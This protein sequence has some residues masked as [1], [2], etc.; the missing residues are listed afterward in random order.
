MGSFLFGCSSGNP[1]ATD[2]DKTSLH[3]ALDAYIDLRFEA[4]PEAT[5]ELVG[6]IE[7]LNLSAADVETMLRAGRASYEPPA[8]KL[9]DYSFDPIDCYHVDYSTKYFIY[10]PAD[11]DASKA[12]PLVFVGHGG[13][14]AMSVDYATSTARSY[15]RTYAPVFGAM[16]GFILVAPAST[17]GWG[18]I[19]NS[20]MFSTISQIE[21]QYHVDP[22]RI[23][24]MGQSMGGHLSYRSGLRFPDHFAAVSPQSGGY[25]Y[26]EMDTVQNLYTI[27]GYATYGTAASGELYGLD[28]VNQTL[29]AWL[30]AHHYPW[31]FAEKDGGHTIYTDELPKIVDFF[32]GHARDL[33]RRTT[34]LR[35]KGSMKFDKTEQNDGWPTVYQINTARPLR[36]NMRN[37]V[38]VTPRPDFDGN[39]T[40]YAAVGDGNR[41]DLTSENVRHL[42]VYLHP[43]MGIDLSQPVEI[44]ANGE[45]RF[46]GRVEVDMRLLLET[47]KEFDDRGRIYYAAVDVDVATDQ[48]VPDPVY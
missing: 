6:R 29:D 47:V 39:L 1:V 28:V 10:V 35:D 18:E 19:G 41:I 38:E 36:W 42:R 7:A 34:Y 5:A 43:K 40:V 9:G 11:Y 44:Y 22:E 12:Y 2:A 24:V 3:A 27:P 30:S 20:L 15:I 21:R 33:Y 32:N 48:A 25:D 8:D 45:L 4:T 13:D 37:F 46:S 14:S 23:Y 31:I 26:V 17:V 16:S